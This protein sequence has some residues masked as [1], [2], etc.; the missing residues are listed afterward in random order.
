MT[1]NQRQ[2]N[3]KAEFQLKTT[4]RKLKKLQMNPPDPLFTASQDF[5]SKPRKQQKQQQD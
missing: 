4:G 2:K 5:E 3:D 1:L